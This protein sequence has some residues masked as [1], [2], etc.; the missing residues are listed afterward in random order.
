MSPPAGHKGFLVSRL[1][2]SCNVLFFDSGHSS[3]NEVLR[4]RGGLDL[5]VLIHSFMSVWTH[6]W[7]FYFL[8]FFHFILYPEPSTFILWFP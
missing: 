7:L 6:G 8:L 2:S 5:R 1:T 3:R 4:A